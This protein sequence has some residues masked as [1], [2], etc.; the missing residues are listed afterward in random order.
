MLAAGIGAFWLYAEVSGGGRSA[1]TADVGAAAPVSGLPTLD[2]LPE[3][4]TY[5][6][7][8]GIRIVRRD[9]TRRVLTTESGLWPAQWSPDG[10]KLLAFRSIE[11]RSYSLVTVGLDGRVSEPI[12]TNVSV[13]ASWSPDGA[14]IAFMRGSRD[15]GQT[16]HVVAAD[17]GVPRPVGTYGQVRVMTGPMFSWSNDGA[18]LVYAGGREGGLFMAVADG[19]AAAY[20]LPT[21]E[22]AMVTAPRWSP[23]GLLIA[24]VVEG[25]AVRP[26]IYVV[27]PDG[28]GLR[29][30]APGGRPQWSPDGSRIAFFHGFD[31]AVVNADGTDLQPLPVCRCDLRGPGF[32]PSFGWSSD[33]T[34]IAYVGGRGN[35]V[36]TVRPDGTGATRVA[37]HRPVQYA[38][39]W[40]PLWRPTEGG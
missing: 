21:L 2:A 12:A 30:V 16:L 38:G 17:G 8:D 33:G 34:R 22:G 13:G 10:S 29:R 5:S 37:I 15:A 39:P 31:A 26:G 25:G 19:R 24:F 20:R 6:Y 1:R 18:R 3:D 7:E 11:G 23:D 14:W 35:A 36:S 32:W 9:G 4:L 27:R 28:T 40:W